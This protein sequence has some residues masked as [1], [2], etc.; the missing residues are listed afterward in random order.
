MKKE[1]PTESD[2]ENQLLFWIDFD[3][4]RQ[5]PFQEFLDD[6]HKKY[7]ELDGDQKADKSSYLNIHSTFL[8]NCV[9]IMKGK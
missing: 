3:I 2:K 7:R 9:R 1:D 5:L 6:I 8:F 4:L